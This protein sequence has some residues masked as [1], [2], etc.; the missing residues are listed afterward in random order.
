MCAKV[1]KRAPKKKG[2]LYKMPD[3]IPAGTI[4][5]DIKGKKWILDKSIGIGGFGE[6]YSGMYRSLRSFPFFFIF[7]LI[8]YLIYHRCTLRR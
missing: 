6:V 7:V 8:K 5:S 4:L 3:P 2:N 1:A